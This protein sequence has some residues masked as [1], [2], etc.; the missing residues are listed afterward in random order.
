MRARGNVG[1]ASK[2]ATCASGFIYQDG[3][4]D[5]TPGIQTSVFKSPR[6]YLD[7]D[8]G[9]KYCFD[10]N[11]SLRP[12]WSHYCQK[13]HEGDESGPR[14]LQPNVTFYCTLSLW[15]MSV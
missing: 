6:A 13:P 4:T 15:V 3:L 7:D 12:S 1:V 9:G 11:N 2:L 5:A 8:V 10:R 14:S